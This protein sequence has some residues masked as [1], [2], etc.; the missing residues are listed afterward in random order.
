VALST[1]L[2]P[3][4]RLRL[5]RGVLRINARGATDTTAFVER[6]RLRG[7]PV[8]RPWVRWAA[9]ARGGTLDYRVGVAPNRRWGA[10]PAD[11]PPSY[12]AEGRR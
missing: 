6:V 11:A 12:S 5:A 1:P 4:A 8:R 9:L 2:F 3:R 10:R 7:A